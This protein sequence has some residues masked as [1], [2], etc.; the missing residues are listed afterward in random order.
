M[1]SEST[2]RRSPNCPPNSDAFRRL[3]AS[4]AYWGVLGNHEIHAVGKDSATF[5][6]LAGIRLLRNAWVVPLGAYLLHAACRRLAAWQLQLGGR[7]PQ[8]LSVNLS[9]AQLNEPTL[10]DEVRHALLLCPAAGRRSCHALA[11]RPSA[12]HRPAARHPAVAQWA[13]AWGKFESLNTETAFT[14][15]RA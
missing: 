9:R 2:L 12:G 6:E 15:S 7:A 14:S 1:C 8:T 3:W 4:G 5:F 10:I 11:G 13:R